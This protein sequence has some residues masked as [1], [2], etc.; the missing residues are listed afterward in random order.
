[1][2]ALTPF[3]RTVGASYDAEQK[4]RDQEA[5]QAYMAALKAGPMVIDNGPSATE[6]FQKHD[7]IAAM[8]DAQLPQALGGQEFGTPGQSGGRAAVADSYRASGA[9]KTQAETNYSTPEAASI[10]TYAAQAK[11]WLGEIKS[12]RD[13]AMTEGHVGALQSLDATAG[14]IA[15]SLNGQSNPATPVTQSETLPDGTIKITSTPPATPYDPTTDINS[16]REQITSSIATRRL[17][18]Q[19]GGTGKATVTVDGV[20]KPAAQFKTEDV[21]PAYKE[22]SDFESTLNVLKDSQQVPSRD[23]KSMITP[24]EWIKESEFGSWAEAMRHRSILFKRWKSAQ[25][26]YNDAVQTAGHAGGQSEIDKWL[27][28]AAK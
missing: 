22:Y 14:K 23:K 3:I 15:A 6:M 18:S 10:P 26:Q 16:A 27:E 21:A 8:K 19:S 17:D 28:D 11:G 12:L 1:M 13:H 25:Q 5:L 20:P 4:R 2:P 9:A 24:D 7:A